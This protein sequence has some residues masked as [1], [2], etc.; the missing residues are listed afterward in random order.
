MAVQ[1]R[2]LALILAL[3]AGPA[4][5]APELP[6][7][8]VLTGRIVAGAES[9]AA[10]PRTGDLVLAFNAADGQ[11]IGSGPVS[12]QGDYLA[13][14]TRT[15]SFNGAPLVLELMQGRRRYALL[16]AG[17]AQGASNLLF[18]GR[19]LPERT[20]LDLRVGAK[21]AELAAGETED[22]Q[23]QRLGGRPEVP[24]MKE[25]DA[26][27]DGRCDQRDWDIMRLYGGGVTRSVAHPD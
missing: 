17:A 25:L 14:L 21:T 15:A 19:A 10:A 18:R 2:L 5:A 23:A 6:A 7:S 20:L 1:L 12:A 13:V 3:A 4:H 27:G 11:L 26:D 24:C 16:P 22:P 8:M 9:A